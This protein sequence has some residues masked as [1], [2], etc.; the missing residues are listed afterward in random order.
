MSADGF[1]FEVFADGADA[2]GRPGTG[3]ELLVAGPAARHRRAPRRLPG[4]MGRSARFRGPGRVPPFVWVAMV[5]ALVIGSLIAQ[6]SGSHGG[7]GRVVAGPSPAAPTDQASA[8]AGGEPSTQTQAIQ[9][10]V[11]MAESP[12]PLMNNLR[13]TT[14]TPPCPQVAPTVDPLGRVRQSMKRYAAAFGVRDSSLTM[15]PDDTLCALEVRAEAPGGATMIIRV[16]APPNMSGPELYF[17]QS[18]DRSSALEVVNVAHGWETEVFWTG[19]TGTLMDY[20]VLDQIAHDA[21]LRW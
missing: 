1:D 12:V 13:S 5:A 21:R 14:A 20:S 8:P 18:N 10:M 6:G 15:D 4:L 9:Q 2:G 11:Y 3:E 16:S 17:E 7:G 19:T